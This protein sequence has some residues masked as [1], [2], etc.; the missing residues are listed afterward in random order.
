M[1]LYEYKCKNC[2]EVFEHLSLVH[3]D[4]PA[5]CP[6]CHCKE[7]TRVPSVGGGFIFIGE[8]FYATAYPKKETEKSD[9]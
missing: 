6:K 2:E 8:G 1:P 3:D 4:L 9:E 7:F 5:E